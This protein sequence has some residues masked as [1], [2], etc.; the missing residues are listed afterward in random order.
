MSETLKGAVPYDDVAARIYARDPQLAAD[1]LN[2]CL[3][4]GEMDEFLV[5]LRHIA[6]AFGGL[7]EVARV[8]GLHEKTLYKSLNPTGN[9]TLKTLL[10]LAAAMNMRLAFVPKTAQPAEP[11]CM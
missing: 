9:P 10:G 3:A 11:S 8:T 5:A 7:H 1:M 4:E 6:K 2:V